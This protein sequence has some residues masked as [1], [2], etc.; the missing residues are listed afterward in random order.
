[1]VHN[2]LYTITVYTAPS[3][4][5]KPQLIHVRDIERQIRAVVLDVEKRISNHEI[6]VPIGVLS[7]DDRDLWA[8]VWSI[9]PHLLLLMQRFRI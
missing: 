5:S 2:Y 1:M 7:A 6:A 3:T 4:S 9:Y 8:K